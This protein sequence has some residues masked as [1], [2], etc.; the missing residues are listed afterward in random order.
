MSRKRKHAKKNKNTIPKTKRNKKQ[1]ALDIKVAQLIVGSIW[2][3]ATS[4]P[5]QTATGKEVL[6]GWQRCKILSRN[7]DQVT[8]KY[9][10]DEEDED[11]ITYDISDFTTS[12]DPA[13]CHLVDLT[14][15]V[16]SSSI[17]FDQPVFVMKERAE[18]VSLQKKRVSDPK[19]WIKNRRNFDSTWYTVQQ[20]AW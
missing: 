2:R 13:P 9:L 20:Q 14:D 6:S 8:V 7:E 17:S 3:V 1:I 18:L 11:P 19:K 10:D 5:V 4:D 12:A 15:H 16:Q